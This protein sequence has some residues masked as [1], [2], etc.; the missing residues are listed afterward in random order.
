MWYGS[1]V[2]NIASRI[3]LS[4]KELDFFLSLLELKHVSKKEYLLRQG[5]VCRHDFYIA[6]GL[7][8]VCYRDEKG[9]ECIIKFASEDWWVVDLDSFINCKPAFYYM[10]ALEDTEVLVISKSN[11]DL[12]LAGVPQFHKFSSDR[13]QAGFIALQQRLMQ[14][15]SLTAEAKYQLFR[16]KYPGLEQRVPQKLIASYLGITPEFLSMLRKK[17]TIVS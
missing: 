10:Q 8:K 11:Y 9:D 13:W 12:L 5:E 1:I 3:S 17:A 14:S 6:S 7:V 2:E 15:L 4:Q 16:D